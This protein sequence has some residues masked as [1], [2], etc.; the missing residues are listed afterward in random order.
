MID[1]D[2][3]MS[4]I[5]RIIPEAAT[6]KLAHPSSAA[7]TEESPG[8]EATPIFQRGE[9]MLVLGVGQA[10]VVPDQDEA[11]PQESEM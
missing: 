9:R 5:I 11:A 8:G 10:H 2:A 1:Q 3:G 6:M 4:S 7:D